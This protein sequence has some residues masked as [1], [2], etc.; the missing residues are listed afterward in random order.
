MPRTPQ[1]P[2]PVYA[3][4]DLYTGENGTLL[5]RDLP[6][7]GSTRLQRLRL[8]PNVSNEN[9]QPMVVYAENFL[10]WNMIRTYAAKFWG[11]DVG[12]VMMRLDGGDRWKELVLW[13]SISTEHLVGD[14]CLDIV[15]S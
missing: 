6:E 14:L 1:E 12:V 5:I 9:I 13:Q 4:E 11:C 15:R 10:T 8:Y 2:L 7:I 3:E